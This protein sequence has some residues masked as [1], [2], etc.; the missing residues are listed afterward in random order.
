[1]FNPVNIKSENDKNENGVYSLEINITFSNSNFTPQIHENN[2]AT[3]IMYPH[4]A[5]L[6]NFTYSSPVTVDFNIN[7]TKRSG[8][9]LNQ[10]ETTF[11]KLNLFILEKFRLC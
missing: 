6:R 2:G 1:M 5:R 7:I 3:K 4:E 10:V 9:E 8:K 11:K